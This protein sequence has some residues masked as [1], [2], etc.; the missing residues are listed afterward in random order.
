MREFARLQSFPDRFG[1][2]TDH[3]RGPLPGRI[4]GGAAHSRYRQAGNAVPPLLAA[5]AA[6]ALRDTVLAAYARRPLL[7]TAAA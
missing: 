6:E 7:A 4:G 2:T 5:A 3:R 1:F